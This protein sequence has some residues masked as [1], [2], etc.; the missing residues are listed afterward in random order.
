M[1]R[2]VGVFLSRSQAPAWERILRSSGAESILIDLRRLGEV[3]SEPA[4]RRHFIS[5]AMALPLS[6]CVG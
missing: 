3:R 4:W 5:M 1:E 2:S 6:G